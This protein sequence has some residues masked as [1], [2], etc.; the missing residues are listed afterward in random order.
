MSTPN[1]PECKGTG[2]ISKKA[3][4]QGPNVDGVHPAINARRP[5]YRTIV[6]IPCP[7]CKGHE[8]RL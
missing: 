2:T 6:Q 3:W 8:P 1:C 5:A 7:S 4:T